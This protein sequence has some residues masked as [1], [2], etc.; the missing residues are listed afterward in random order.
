[1]GHAYYEFQ[2][3][4]LANVGSGKKRQPSAGPSQ[5]P[6]AEEA[7]GGSKLQSAPRV[8]QPPGGA[9]SNIFGPPE[10]ATPSRTPRA[11]KMSSSIPFGDTVDSTPSSNG[12]SPP[13]TPVKTAAPNPV[14]GQG[15]ETPAAEEKKATPAPS[16]PARRRIPPGGFSSPLW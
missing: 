12:S 10:E 7:A 2:H 1:M 5:D 11:N 13:A 4:E 6:L 15:Y 9:S 3:V 8:R 14:T 16:Q